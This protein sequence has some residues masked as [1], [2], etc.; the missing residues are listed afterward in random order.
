AHHPEKFWT[1]LATAGLWAAQIGIEA[2]SSELLIKI[3]KGTRVIQNLMAQK[4]LCELGVSSQSNLITHH[5]KSTLADIEETKR[6]LLATPHF[7]EL[8]LCHFRLG[9]ESP[10]FE[11]L[12]AEE[13]SNLKLFS[14]GKIAGQLPEFASDWGYE[15]PESL[16]LSP[17]LHEAWDEF[18]HWY[19]TVYRR[20]IS[21]KTHLT[22]KRRSEGRLTVTDARGPKLQVIEL[23]GT[24]A[25]LYDHCHK[26]SRREELLGLG[27]DEATLDSDL[28]F[29]TAS[30]LLI[31][32]DQ[33]FLSL[34]L[35]PKS[36]LLG[37]LRE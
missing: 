21:E 2:L 13:K 20:A 35:R 6:V 27:W 15:L 12:S 9:E 5:P 28:S 24:R 18:L 32:V 10:I 7:P 33:A 37:A 26:A 3:G 8:N 4:Y 34:A 22:V 36:E 25:R 23:E 29:L 16:K 30:N 14:D 1:K 11:A 31:E 17:E 19:K